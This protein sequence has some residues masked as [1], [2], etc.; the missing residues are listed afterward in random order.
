MEQ[1]K[2]DLKIK[3]W[4]GL[5]SFLLA[6]SFFVPGSIYLV[7]NL[8]TAIGPIAYNLADFLYG[9]VWSACLITVIFVLRE[10]LSEYAPR[11]MSLTLLAAFLAAGAMVAVALIRSSNRQYH[12]M[13]PE[14]NLENSITVLVVWATLV[15][16]VTSVGWHFLG[17]VQILIGSAGW[18]SRQLPRP[19][20]LLYFAGGVVS[21][22]VYLFPGNEGLAMLLG[23]IISIWQG[24]LLWNAK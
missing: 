22:F 7:G 1:S 3:K 17:W 10:Q 19:L 8:Q 15:T 5:A 20:N 18:T 14:L 12:I 9:P 13:H 16:G 2:I 21:L 11:R 23:M 6:V 4:G 24:I